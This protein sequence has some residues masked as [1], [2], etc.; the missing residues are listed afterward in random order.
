MFKH[1][2]TTVVLGGVALLLASAGIASA[3]WTLIDD[4]ND[5]NDEGWTRID[6]L[7]EGEGGG[8][9]II[10]PESGAYHLHSTSS[11]PPIAFANSVNS[12]WEAPSDAIYSNGFLRAKIRNNVVHTD[13]GLAMRV[14][15]EKDFSGY[16]FIASSYFD[17]PLCSIGKISEGR[18]WTTLTNQGLRPRFSS[19]EDWTVEA[20]V[21][22]DQLSMK[23]WRDGSPE[24]TTPQLLVTDPTLPDGQFLIFNWLGTANPS[25]FPLDATFDDIYFH[26]PVPGDFDSDR[27]VDVKDIDLLSAEIRRGRYRQQ[28]DLNDDKSVDMIDH[29]IWVHELK[30]TW[31]G[32]AD[33]NDEFNSHDFVQVFQE[34]KYETALAAGWAE[35]D[36]DASGTFDSS[37]FVVAFQD[38]GYELGKRTDVAAVPEPGAWAMLVIGLVVWLFGRRTCAN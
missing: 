19:Y 10:E 14:N 9:G 28:F 12:L 2:I 24:P 30:N 37:D 17:P 16:Y 36:W 29:G 8:P 18:N 7:S 5:G 11:V 20:G 27:V 1:F 25:P 3:Q 6:L 15:P 13:V 26:P 35:G 22:G 21:V 23:V 4:F 34:G 33:L 31:Y 32:D 38:G